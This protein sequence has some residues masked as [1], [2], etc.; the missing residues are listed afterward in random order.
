M[1]GWATGLY[2]MFIAPC[3]IWDYSVLLNSLLRLVVNKKT[4]S[5]S[6]ESFSWIHILRSLLSSRCYN[7]KFSMKIVHAWVLYFCLYPSN[8]MCVFRV[9]W[10]DG[11]HRARAAV[12][13][14]RAPWLGVCACCREKDSQHQ[15]FG[16]QAKAVEAPQSSPCAPLS[17]RRAQAALCCLGWTCGACEGPGGLRCPG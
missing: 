13:V 14:D 1:C 8:S 15:W 2:W 17:A 16:C 7:M 4:L 12:E 5:L 10:W 3:W 11:I 9:S 6:C